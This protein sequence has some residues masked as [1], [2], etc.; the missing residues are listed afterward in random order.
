[1]SRSSS[2]I[3]AGLTAAA[4]AV[5]GFLAYQASA[6]APSTLGA[7]AAPS[8]SPS[9]VA[10]GPQRPREDPT[11]LPTGSGQGARV[12]YGLKA[13]RVWLVGKDGAVTRTFTVQPSTVDPTAGS[14]TVTQRSDSLTGSDGV[15]IEHDVIFAKVGTVVIGFSAARDGST[16]APDPSKKTGGVRMKRADADALWTFATFGST[17]VVLP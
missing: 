5:V 15:P 14:Y 12:V 13:H 6:N 17:I 11:A 9:R 4:L 8:A 3:V 7:T 10:H 16:P 2:G 1:M